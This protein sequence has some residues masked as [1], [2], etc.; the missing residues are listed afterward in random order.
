MI[1]LDIVVTNEATKREKTIL[2]M[3]IN[4]LTK[5]LGTIGNILPIRNEA[6]L[7]KI[8]MKTMRV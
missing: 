2:R 5:D 6:N 1:N 7:N 8:M 4:T 3:I